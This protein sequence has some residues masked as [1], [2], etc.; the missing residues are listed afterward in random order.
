MG[1]ARSD[2]KLAMNQIPR[3]VNLKG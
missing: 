2:S 1:L 3:N